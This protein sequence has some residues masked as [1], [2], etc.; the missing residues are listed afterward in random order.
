MWFRHIFKPKSITTLLFTKSQPKVSVGKSVVSIYSNT[1]I[2]Y[3]DYLYIDSTIRGQGCGG[4]LL[5]V[6]EK[7]TMQKGY[8]KQIYLYA[9]N[10]IF[11]DS[12]TN[13]YKKFNYKIDKNIPTG[14]YDDGH[15]TFDVVP[16]YKN[17]IRYT[18][19]EME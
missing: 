1:N 6:T 19:F 7:V 13:F 2:A 3:I 12:L 11:D 5:Q 16:M 4:E 17:I 18:N 14:T 8:I 10:E 15:K 9:H